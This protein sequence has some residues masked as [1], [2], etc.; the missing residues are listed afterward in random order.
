MF[1]GDLASWQS[2][3]LMCQQSNRG[4]ESIISNKKPHVLLT[5]R[6]VVLIYWCVC[7]HI[8]PQRLAT[9]LPE[10]QHT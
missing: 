1:Q 7:G 5:Q 6:C 10:V 9:G 4:P 3:P 2:Y 8:L